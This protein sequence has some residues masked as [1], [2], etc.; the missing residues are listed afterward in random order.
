MRDRLKWPRCLHW[1]GWLP[2]L[3]LGGDRAP[4]ADSLGRLAVRPSELVSGGYPVDNS[5]FWSPPD[6]LDA[7]DLAIETG[8]SP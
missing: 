1:C 3:G 8:D 5:C 7:E 6:F 4:W 2:G